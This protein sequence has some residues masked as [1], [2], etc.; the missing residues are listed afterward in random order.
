MLA[1]ATGHCPHAESKY[2]YI[3]YNIVLYVNSTCMHTCVYFY[4]YIYIHVEIYLYKGAHRM[5]YV[6]VCV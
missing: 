2:V 5:Y 6:C 3:I 1:S 4:M